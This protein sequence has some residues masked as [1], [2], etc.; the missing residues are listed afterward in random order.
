M[1][2]Y[3]HRL[4]CFCFFAGIFAGGAGGCAAVFVAVTVEAESEEERD[5]LDDVR[6]CWDCG[7]A[8]WLELGAKDHMLATWLKL[9]GMVA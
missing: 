3:Q 5:G 9:S 1:R 6:L 8:I 7:M 2:I 4:D